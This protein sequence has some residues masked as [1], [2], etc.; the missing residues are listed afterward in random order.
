M[1]PLAERYWLLP[2]LRERDQKPEP[3]QRDDVDR[4]MRERPLC[5]SEADDLRRHL[6]AA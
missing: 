3:E 4:I 1:I 5:E 2:H 6:E